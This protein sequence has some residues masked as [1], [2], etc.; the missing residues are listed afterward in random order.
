[1]LKVTSKDYSFV[2]ED[3]LSEL[4]TIFHQHKVK[5]NLLQNAAI[6]LIACVDNNPAKIEPLISDLSLNYQI[7]RNED[8]ELL[9]I[10]HYNDPTFERLTKDRKV[11]LEQKSR[12]T[13]QAVMSNF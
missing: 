4:Y 11:L 13:V 7:R 8:A 6:S 3:K 2:T 9:T 5:I 10:R 12:V 1:M